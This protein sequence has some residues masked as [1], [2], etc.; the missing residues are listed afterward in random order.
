MLRL[1]AGLG[2]SEPLPERLKPNGY[3]DAPMSVN[4]A[5]VEGRRAVDYATLEE[6]VADAE[7]LGA[8]PSRTL[9]NWSAGQI[10]Q[11]LA[12]VYNGSIDGFAYA[13]PWPLRLLAKA[14]K[15]KLLGGPMPAGLQVPAAF[16]KEVMPVPTSTE[17]GLA[18]LRDAVAR[19]KSEPRRAR[20]PILGD[21]TREGWD[22]IH[23]K[24]A[25]L[26]MSFLAPA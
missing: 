17:E 25:N 8:G 5:K 13:F 2:P 10:Y 3:E 20:H 22:R 19:L 12:T 15:G 7:R 6:V 1:R 23:L 14:F 4:T 11:H 24:H 9:G 18:A 21:F 26:H 16:A